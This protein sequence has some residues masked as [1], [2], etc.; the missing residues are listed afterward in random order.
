VSPTPLA[1]PDQPDDIPSQQ[2]LDDAEFILFA[3][4]PRQVAR[5]VCACGADYPCDDVRFAHLVREAL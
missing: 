4:P 1:D 2:D 3:H 5:L